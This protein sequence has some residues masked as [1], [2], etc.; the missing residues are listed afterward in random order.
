VKVIPSKQSVEMTHTAK[1][2][3]VVIGVGV[4]NFIYQWRHNGINITGE[5]GDIL[6]LTKV[7]KRHRG[8]YDCIVTNEYGVYAIS[9]KANLK[10]LSMCNYDAINLCF[11][12]H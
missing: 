7:T 8:I 1:F 3:T 2:S 4:G 9:N 10:I 5:T 12:L 11:K 6:L